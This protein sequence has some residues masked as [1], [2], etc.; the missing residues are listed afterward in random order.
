MVTSPRRKL[1]GLPFD[2]LACSWTKVILT[3]SLMSRG[4]LFA[5][6]HGNTRAR[7]PLTHLLMAAS[8]PL[9]CML[10]DIDMMAVFKVLTKQ[11]EEGKNK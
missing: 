3:I 1:N 10:D 4:V 7:C 11:S 5:F 9:A 8:L 6:K 2:L